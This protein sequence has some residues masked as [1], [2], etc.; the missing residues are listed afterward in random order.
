MRFFEPT[1]WRILYTVL[2]FLPLLSLTY[3]ALAEC[4]PVTGF[5]LPGS[6]YILYTSQCGLLSDLERTNANVL[7]YIYIPIIIVFVSCIL[8]SFLA[9]LVKN[10]AAAHL[11]IAAALCILNI[12]L[13]V[14]WSYTISALQETRSEEIPAL[15]KDMKIPTAPLT[16]LPTQPTPARY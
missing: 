4:F 15:L 2:L 8:A 9:L 14:Q 12:L 3:Y 7:L 16:S 13:C 11:I 5:T 10:G 1:K 6:Q